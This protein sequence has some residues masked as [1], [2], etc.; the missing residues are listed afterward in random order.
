MTQHDPFN[1]EAAF[2]V[3]RATP[4]PMP[5]ALTARIFADAVAH[6]PRKPIW[7]RL[8]NA[9]GGPA[10]M[11][12]LVTATVAGFWFGVTPPA[13]GYDPLLLVSA[14]EQQVDEDFTDLVGFGLTDF[15][16]SNDEVQQD[17]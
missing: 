5:E 4:A 15:G 12:G 1:L 14:V 17:G 7:V 16:W 8:L 9:I 10:G 3:A 11:G 6:Q 13:D 2:D